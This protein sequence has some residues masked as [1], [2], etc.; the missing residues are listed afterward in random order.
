MRNKIANTETKI[1]ISATELII[2]IG[3]FTPDRLLDKSKALPPSLLH[4]SLAP[5]F[6]PSLPPSAICPFP[7]MLFLLAKEREKKRKAQKVKSHTPGSF[8]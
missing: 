7:K 5:S 8:F 4:A 6:P 1:K 2:S 3:S